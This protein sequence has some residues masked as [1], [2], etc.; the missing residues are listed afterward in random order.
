M[1]ASPDVPN[2]ATMPATMTTNAPVGP[3]IWRREPPSAEIRNP[4]TGGVKARLRRH[5]RRDVE[6]HRQRQ[7]HQSVGYSRDEVVDELL[8]GVA[9]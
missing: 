6:C 3:P 7:G 4:A 2:F 8:Q 1:S 5:S 9:A